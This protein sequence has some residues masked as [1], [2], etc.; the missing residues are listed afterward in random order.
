MTHQRAMIGDAL[1][2]RG[3]VLPFAQ[4]LHNEQK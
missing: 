3:K 4:S 1:E 2:S